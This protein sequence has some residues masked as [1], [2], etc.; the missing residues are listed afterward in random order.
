MPPENLTTEERELLAVEA[1]RDVPGLISA[2][3]T[4]RQI[5]EDGTEVGVSR[6]ACDYAAALLEYWQARA[7]TVAPS[8]VLETKCHRCG[9]S[10]TIEVWEGYAQWPEKK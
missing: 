5:D 9:H 4:Q 10:A 8:K 7:A 3:R 6:Q 1:L 2:L